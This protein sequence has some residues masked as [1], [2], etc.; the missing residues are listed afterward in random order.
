MIISPFWTEAAGDGGGS[1]VKQNVSE[2][3]LQRKSIVVKL[4]MMRI[5]ACGCSHQ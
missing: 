1:S 4:P 3:R 2:E 5:F